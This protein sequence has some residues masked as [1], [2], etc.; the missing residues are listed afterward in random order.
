V[1]LLSPEAVQPSRWPRIHRAPRSGSVDDVDGHLDAEKNLEIM[2][3]ELAKA[4]VIGTVTG[5]LDFVAT[6]GWMHRSLTH[7]AYKLAPPLEHGA[8]AIIWGTGTRPR[9]WATVHRAHHEHADAVGD[10]HSPVLQGRY[11]VA[12][13]FV[14][15]TPKY[16]RAARAV[17]KEDV[18]AADLQPDH[19]D[20]VIFDKTRAGLGA[21]LLGH[22]SLNKGIGNP[23]Y[24]G[25][26]SWVIEKAVYISGGNLVNSLG[27]AGL[28]PFKALVS[29]QI[30][31]Q[32]DG[33]FG[34][35]SMVVSLLTLGEGNQ[36]YHHQHPRSL[37]FGE[38]PERA[39]LLARAAKDFGGTAAL[40]LVRSNLATTDVNSD[41]FELAR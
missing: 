28:H 2:R 19:L 21:S 35:D 1:G 34:A 23:G 16:G 31:P 24:M 7:K 33:T 14:K 37:Y 10:P 4:A 22:I 29:G 3:R 11:G 6:T 18:F 20:R 12:K 26:I 30:K 13:L 17:E 40:L 25:A 27:H 41:A 32:P 9:V 39:P 36:R 15:N 38:H 5:L 8:R